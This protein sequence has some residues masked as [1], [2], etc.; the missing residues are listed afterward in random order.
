MTTPETRRSSPRTV[1]EM[2]ASSAVHAR[3]RVLF[4]AR[5]GGACSTGIGRYARTI[6]EVL[7]EGV[8]GV[9]AHLLGP[10]LELDLALASREEEE[11]VLP[12][13]LDHERID[14]FHSP[15][16]RIPAI[17]SC[18]TVVTVHDAIPLVHPELCEPGFKRL[19]DAEA[20]KAVARADAVVCP[21]ESARGDLVRLMGVPAE[22]VHVVPECPAE[23]FR[24]VDR[25]ERVR[26]RDRYELPED[27]VLAIGSLEPRKNPGL[28]LDA[29]V[30]LGRS[31]ARAPLLVFAGP[32]AGF[33]L[34]AEARQRGL[35]GEA[36]HLGLVGD[37]DLV[38]LL[39]EARALVHPSRYEGFGL[40]I[41][42]AFACGTPVLAARTGSIPEVAGGAAI[43]FDPDDAE[44]LAEAL[45]RVERSS[46]L[47]D[48]LCLRGRERVEERFSR[49][50]V[51]KA[52][53]G[54]Y[55][56]L[57]EASS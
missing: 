2:A 22:K 46:A 43:L 34:E 18:R 37:E 25:A 11:L 42:E 26:V 30:S 27:Y 10:G 16:F 19:F 14:V 33:D 57:V 13:I 12:T 24:P 55:A 31:G 44:G 1:A 9:E 45:V 35:A 40:P 8:E 39:C 21:S 51:R 56:S 29:L 53:A 23:C 3:A 49:A 6:A 38:A 4:D 15:L 48:G 28:L 17:K 20:A 41:V 54:L 7:I 52:L 32:A 50:A 47:R 36:R 5:P